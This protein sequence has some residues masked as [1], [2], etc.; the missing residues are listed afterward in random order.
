M[1]LARTLHGKP[2]GFGELGV[3]LPPDPYP[4]GAGIQAAAGVGIGHPEGVVN[5][6]DLVGVLGREEVPGNEPF[7]P[8]K[9]QEG[10]FAAHY[11]RFSF[12]KLKFFSC[13]RRV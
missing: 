13:D 7:L 2:G 8:G 9:G 12:P 1:D 4:G 3:S 10:L 6:G 5:A 11:K